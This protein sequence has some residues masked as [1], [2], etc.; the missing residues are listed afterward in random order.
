VDLLSQPGLKRLSVIA[1]RAT[2]FQKRWSN[3]AH[4]PLLQSSE[5][6]AK[7]SGRL[8]LGESATKGEDRCLH[9][10]NLD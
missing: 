8:T 5:A 6:D 3:A 7:F 1:N 9:G 2:K 10:G 4:A